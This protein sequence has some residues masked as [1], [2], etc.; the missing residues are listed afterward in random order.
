MSGSDE[1]DKKDSLTLRR[2]GRLELRKTVETG[3]V[4]QS[5]SHGRSKVV[6]VEVRR[7]RTFALGKGGRMTEVQEMPAEA[8][9]PDSSPAE[10]VTDAPTSEA[11][12]EGA[13][14]ARR[15]AVLK[16]LTAEEKEARARALGIA[17][18]ADQVARK[19]AAIET[20]ALLEAESAAEAERAAEAEERRKGEEEERRKAEEEAERAAAEAKEPA[21]PSPP[22]RARLE[23]VEEP[24][25]VPARGRRGKGEVRRSSLAARRGPQ[26]RRSSKLTISQALTEEDRVRSLASVR[27]AREREREKRTGQPK[28]PS[29]PVKVV[30]EVV[31]PESITVQELA[32][33]MA[34]RGVEV[35]KAA[36]KI[37]SMATINQTIDADA[38]ELLVHEFG[39]KVKRVSAADVEL[40]L[41]GE[42]DA[43]A[44]LK[45]RPPVVTVMGHVDHGKTSLLDVL[46]KTNVAGGEAGGITQHIGA[47]QVTLDS[48]ATLTFIDTPGHEA[49]TAMRAR[50][51]RVTDIVV[52]VIAADDGVMPQTVEAINHAKAAGVPIVVA[53]N[54]IDR[55]DADANAVRND[56]LQHEVVVEELGGEVLSVEV[57]ATEKLNLDKLVE[58]I[59]LQA[60]LL[61]LTANPERPAEGVV[62][63]AKLDRGRGPVA[64]VLVQR[65]TLRVGEIVVAGSYWARVRALLNDRGH[66]VDEAGPTVPVELLGLNGV[67]SAGD[68]VVVVD[69]E[70]RARE[71]TEYR[72]QR[73]NEIRTA[74]GARGTLEQMFADIAAGEA[75]VLPVV[76]KAD[77][78]GSVEALASSL[79]KIGTDEVAVRMLHTGVGGIN[80]ADITLAH[81]SQALV[82]GFNVRANVQARQLARRDNVEIRYY[83]VIYEVIDDVKAALSGLLPPAL[84]ERIIGNA[85]VLEVFD[86]TKV[87]KIAGC[88]VTDGTIKRGAKVRLLRDEVVIYEG[89]LAT[90][91]R[92]KDDARQ[93]KEGLEC[94]MAFENYHDIHPGDII[95]AV[96][97]EEIARTL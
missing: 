44:K 32:N 87:G 4:R 52:L 91:K 97:V 34:V 22:G 92:F 17:R 89:K 30:R 13:Q 24:G 2:P 8:A 61:D 16:T 67:P 55:P 3:Q 96:E 79:E 56:L 71:V 51:A 69:S 12:E 33:R 39:H 46:R 38:A 43:E 86:I 80:E 81:A 37:G 95:E 10:A 70:R 82:I 59:L 78:Q 53:I 88:R 47:Y 27:R 57:S 75:K 20:E 26:R 66:R 60:E 15:T 31:V 35:I 5:F 76:I 21:K 42:T 62:V 68:D 11:L 73:L 77:V 25:S 1:T 41:K 84:R 93:V 18:R 6:T 74:A 9:E 45:P 28:P 83:S 48:G 49:F 29:E 63:D 36:M 50:G 65:G 23:L 14:A 72:Q 90:L 7:K 94:G 58:V 19:Q 64:T 40:G 54:K 85:Q